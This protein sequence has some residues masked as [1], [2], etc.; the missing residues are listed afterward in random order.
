MIDVLRGSNNEKI[1]SFDHHKLTTYGIGK[2]LSDGEVVQGSPAFNYG[3]FAKSFVHFR[4]LPKI[5][6]DLEELK[7]QQ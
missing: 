4:N 6:S 7:K 3:D 1:L 2:N 5:V